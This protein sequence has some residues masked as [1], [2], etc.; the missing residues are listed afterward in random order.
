MERICDSLFEA[1]HITD[2]IESGSLSKKQKRVVVGWS[3]I[4]IW[5]DSKMLNY[6]PGKLD[7]GPCEELFELLS[8]SDTQIK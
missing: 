7:Y 6:T 8:K 1:E 5:L 2:L 4:N 3:V